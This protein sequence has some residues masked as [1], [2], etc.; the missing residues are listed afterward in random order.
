MSRSF[1]LALPY[2]FGATGENTLH[3]FGAVNLISIPISEFK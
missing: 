1:A 3:V 2:I